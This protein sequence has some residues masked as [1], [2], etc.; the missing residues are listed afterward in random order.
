MVVLE[1]SS[2]EM[3]NIFAGWLSL[4]EFNASISISNFTN[5]IF[6]IPS[7]IS[8][9]TSIMV[10]NLIGNQSIPKTH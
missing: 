4:I 1:W 6:M 8:E 2:Y 7:G 3:I 10:G 9:S 5:L